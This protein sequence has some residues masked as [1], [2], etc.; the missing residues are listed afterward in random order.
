M[1]TCRYDAES[2]LNELNSLRMVYYFERQHLWKALA[3][4]RGQAIQEF[5]KT[6][7]SPFLKWVTRRG[8]RGR[9]W[10]VALMPIK[11]NV[12]IVER[13]ISPAMASWQRV[14]DWVDA[15]INMIEEIDHDELIGVNMTIKPEMLQ[16]A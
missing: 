11:D 13:H 9:I 16:E 4:Q 10:V 12:D 1:T 15:A 7:S 5:G 8:S 2:R 3:I 6:G 14:K